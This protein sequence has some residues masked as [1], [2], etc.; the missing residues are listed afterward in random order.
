MNVKCSG[1]GVQKVVTKSAVSLPLS[2][3]IPSC[4]TLNT[5]YGG[6]EEQP[7]RHNFLI[8]RMLRRELQRTCCRTRLYSKGG[9]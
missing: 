9:K 3:Q 2:A 6:G 4:R 5:E 7:I 8:R 1:F